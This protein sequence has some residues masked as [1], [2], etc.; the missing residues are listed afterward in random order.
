MLDFPIT[1][2]LSWKQRKHASQTRTHIFAFNPKGFA[3]GTSDGPGRVGAKP[4]PSPSLVGT[5]IT[6]DGGRVSL[7]L[8][9]YSTKLPKQDTELFVSH[10]IVIRYGNVKYTWR[11]LLTELLWEGWV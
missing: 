6:P 3:V 10:H 4:D 7:A 5:K 2:G 1:E 8:K 9:L 11:F